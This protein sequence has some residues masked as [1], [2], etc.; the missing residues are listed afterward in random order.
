MSDVST[1][2][3]GGN[4]STHLLYGALFTAI[5][6]VALVALVVLRSQTDTSS[7]ST[8]VGNAAPTLDSVVTSTTQGGVDVAAVTL[9]ENTNTTTWFRATATDNNG[10][11]QIDAASNYTGKVYR[12]NVTGG[13]SCT[14]D[15]NDCYTLGS[16][17]VV[18]ASCA[19]GG[20]DLSAQADGNVALAHYTDPTDAGAPQAATNWTASVTVTDDA[21]AA[22]TG[23]DAFEVSSLIALDV[24]GTI[25]YGSIAL[26]ATSTQQATTV[27]NTGNRNMDAEVSGTAMTCGIGSVAVG[28]QKWSL[29][30]GF[31]YDTAGTALTGTAVNSQN[32]TA[33]RTNDATASTTS[34]YWLVR[35]PGTGVQGSC[36]GTNTFTAIADV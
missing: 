18:A 25:P 21:S 23:T 15:N 14:A 19:A 3:S 35:L 1:S 17:T 11:E 33:Q 22:A 16:I 24:T 29:T 26:G 28:Q 10:C 4:S 7:T 27:T 30:T 36:T 2:A 8:T 31:A 32:S 13:A 12:T 34:E 20:A 9:T 6:I 5:A